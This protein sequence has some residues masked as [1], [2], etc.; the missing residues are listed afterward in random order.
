[1]SSDFKVTGQAFGIRTAA[2]QQRRLHG[3]LTSMT[4]KEGRVRRHLGVVLRHDRSGICEQRDARV[5][6]VR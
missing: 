4:E 1:M 5:A 2:G 6:V 3:Q